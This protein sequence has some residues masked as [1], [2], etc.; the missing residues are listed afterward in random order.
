MRIAISVSEEEKAKG[1]ESS[2][3]KAAAGRGRERARRLKVVS[4]S[5][6]A[7]PNFKD[8]DGVLFRGRKK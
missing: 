7:L 3:Y 6:P 4:P 8:Y 2:Y 1:A 5:H